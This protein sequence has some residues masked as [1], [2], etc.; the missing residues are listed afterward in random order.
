MSLSNLNMRVPMD[1][2]VYTNN[3]PKKYLMIFVISINFLKFTRAISI[4]LHE[5]CLLFQKLR[6]VFLDKRVKNL[7]IT[8]KTRLSKCLTWRPILASFYKRAKELFELSAD[9]FVELPKVSNFLFFLLVHFC[10][11][12]FHL[13]K[14]LFHLCI[15]LFKPWVRLLKPSI[16][17]HEF[18]ASWYPR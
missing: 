11:L 4:F 5:S 7:E 3:M 14:L 12:F 1:T 18:H 13:F 16:F 15:L 10:M 17:C 2:R 6:K 9:L 8:S